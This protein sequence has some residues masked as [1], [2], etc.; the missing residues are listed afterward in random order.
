VGEPRQPSFAFVDDEGGDALDALRGVGLG[1]HRERVRDVAV[2]DELFLAAEAPAVAVAGR[3]RLEARGVRAARGF[4]EAP[5]AK[6][7]SGGQGRH[8]LVDLVLG[9]RLV[10]VLG[11]QA[12][13]GGDAEA[14]GPADLADLL[15]DDRVTDGV[16]ARAAV[17]GVDGH[18]QE[19]LVGHLG[20]EV[21]GP[22]VVLVDL[23]GQGGDLALREFPD[24]LPKQFMVGR[25]TIV[26][27]RRADFG[28]RPLIFGPW[29]TVSWCAPRNRRTPRKVITAR[30]TALLGQVRPKVW[31]VDVRFVAL[32]LVGALCLGGCVGAAGSDKK[33]VAPTVSSS[34]APAT[35]TTD[36]GGI[37]G[38]VVN[39]EQLPIKGATVGLTEKALQTQ[40]AVDGRFSF[41]NLEP[42]E[43]TIN[44]QSLG[45]ESTAKK[46]TVTAGS[47]TNVTL[48]LKT[49]VVIETRQENYQYSG[50]LYWAVVTPVAR[51]ASWFV[52]GGD[53]NYFQN[54]GTKG[55]KTVVDALV[56]QSSAPGTAK[57]L[58]IQ[59][60]YDEKG[61][62]DQNST[63]SPAIAR[64][65]EPKTKKSVGHYVWTPFTATQPDEAVTVVYQQ[66]FDIYASFFYGE[67][68][69]ENYSPAPR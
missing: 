27:G 34:A 59:L 40:T 2:G 65:D 41:S 54:N 32:C 17:V 3:D 39:D 60:Y 28:A 29:T 48:T 19:A 33:A 1:H 21:V 49:M 55:V 18:A 45:H 50:F 5:R 4:R 26:H 11:A 31:A 24:G 13:M 10:D 30:G 63:R 53:K 12:V 16:E 38:V 36:T 56:W 14:D 68:A 62:T 22:P 51:V 43:Y 42:R 44:A 61:S 7:L 58:G 52:G 9:A 15:H 6:L 47:V 69:P 23:L 25:G 20:H 35:V 8:E 37:E 66:K 64:G 57:R 46:S 67:A